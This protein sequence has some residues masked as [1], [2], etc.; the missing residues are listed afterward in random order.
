MQ[1]HAT[2]LTITIVVFALVSAL[3]FVATRWRRAE[4]LHTL[5]Q[6]ALAGRGF[7]SWISWFVVGGDLYT[8]YTYVAVPALLF[9]SGAIGFY[10]LPYVAIEYPLVF[11]LMIRLW[12]VCKTHGYVTPADFVRGRFGSPT[13][14]LAVAI[15][16]IVATMPYI[17]LNLL[18]IQAVFTTIGVSGHWPLVIAFAVLAAFT[19]RSGVRAPALISF[20]KDI[21]VYVVIGVAIIYIP[22]RLGG[23]THI[24]D[25]YNAHFEAA[26]PHTATLLTSANQYQYITLALGSAFAIFLYPHSVTG[27]L[28]TKN[29]AVVKRTLAGL[30]IYSFVLGLIALF[31]VMAIAAGTKPLT[32][33]NGKPDTNTVVPNMFEN[34]FPHWFTGLAFGMIVIGALVPAAFM[35]IAA[36]NLFTRNIYKEYL[37]RGASAREE[38]EVSKIASLVVKAGALLF[39]LLIDPQFSIDLQ[40]LGGAIILQTLP[41]VFIGLYTAWLHRGALI[42]GWVAGIATSIWTFYLTPNTALKQPHWGGTAFALSH[43]GMHTEVQLYIGFIGV[44]VNLVVA[45]AGTALLKLLKVR[46]GTD[47]TAPPDYFTDVADKEERPLEPELAA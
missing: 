7:R 35:S 2:E 21:L 32:G 14:A 13:L 37:R 46:G 1:V 24:F 22:M 15:T 12:S 42:A 23:W 39:I 4:P 26:P 18:G 17:A 8:A 44:V 29:R 47:Q 25:S 19:Y 5:D 20:V 3:G 27:V 43:L 34:I 38:T 28:T 45:F 10:A 9:G 16:G 11:L 31:G 36:A 6:W 30:P 41:S 33:A 40:L